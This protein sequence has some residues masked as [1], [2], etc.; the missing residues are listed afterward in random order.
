[1]AAKV[2]F[3]PATKTIQVT[4][5]PSGTPP[6]VT[7][8]V[9]VDL[10]SDA[11]EDWLATPSLQK[12]RFPIQPLG[13]DPVPIGVLGDSYI[14]LAG[15]HL[16]P[17]E[18]DHEFIIEG[19]LFPEVG[20]E[21]VADTLG[22]YRVTVTRQVSTLVE[23]RIDSTQLAEQTL[24]RQILDNRLKTDPATGVMTLYKDDGVTP[25]REWP[26]WEDT[27]QTQPYR[28]QGTEE[29]GAPADLT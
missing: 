13:G 6:T 14:M 5:V 9:K 11:K 2:S 29:R 23:V 21:L 19:N 26:I 17:H 10:Y 4:E 22:A 12:M 20:Y 18:S 27:G 15:W 16:H 7:L 24:M 8:N 28:S 3:D 1:M 25:L